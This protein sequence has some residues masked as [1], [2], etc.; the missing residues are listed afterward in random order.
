MFLPASK[1]KVPA[2]VLKEVLDFFDGVPNGT[3]FP[4]K[5]AKALITVI[6]REK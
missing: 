2:G 5:E 6:L 3:P 4:P 1:A